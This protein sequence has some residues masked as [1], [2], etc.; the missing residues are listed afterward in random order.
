VGAYCL[1]TDFWGTEAKG[2]NAG[3]EY[4]VGMLV[5]TS[6]CVWY[7][8]DQEE[9]FEKARGEILDEIINLSQVSP[10]HWFVIAY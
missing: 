2:L 7:V 6:M 4:L 3:L 8:C 5:V 10:Q 1:G 9:L